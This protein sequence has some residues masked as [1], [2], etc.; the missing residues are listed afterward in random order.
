MQLLAQNL[1]LARLFWRKLVYAP[2]T[3]STAA[4]VIVDLQIT[5]L[6]TGQDLSLGLGVGQNAAAMAALAFP[7]PIT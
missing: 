2:R 1:Q 3:S 5:A 6:Q 7:A 4:D